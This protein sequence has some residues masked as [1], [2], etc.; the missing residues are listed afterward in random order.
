MAHLQFIEDKKG[1]IVDQVVFCSD[2][3]HQSHPD[4]DG[5][6]GCIEISTSE[7]CAKCNQLI[8]G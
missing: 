1:D 6:N 2:Y 4:Y 7:I 5:W 3:C 8:I